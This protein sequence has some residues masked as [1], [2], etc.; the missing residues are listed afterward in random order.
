MSLHFCFV[1]FMLK[2]LQYVKGRGQNRAI[3]ERRDPMFS[4]QHAMRALHAVSVSA[5]LDL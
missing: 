4:S 3:P 2:I 5:I 1:S